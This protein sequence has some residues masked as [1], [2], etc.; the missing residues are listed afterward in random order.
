MQALRSQLKKSFLGYRIFPQL[1]G[2]SCSFNTPCQLRSSWLHHSSYCRS[3]CWPASN[4]EADAQCC[5]AILISGQAL[6]S[7]PYTFGRNNIQSNLSFY[8][9]T[10]SNEPSQSFS[11]PQ[12]IQWSELLLQPDICMQLSLCLTSILHQ[13]Y[14]KI[15]V[16]SFSEVGPSSTKGWTGPSSIYLGGKVTRLDAKLTLDK[17]VPSYSVVT[18]L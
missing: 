13:Y 10:D 3:Q 16:F 6:A 17:H 8:F 12:F 1:N 11:F 9:K 4:A 15:Q 7:Q 14:K 18:A 2:S 5:I